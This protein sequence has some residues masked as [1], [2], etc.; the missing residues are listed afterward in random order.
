M[1]QFAVSA[2]ENPDEAS[3]ICCGVGELD[4]GL[5]LREAGSEQMAKKKSTNR[6]REENRGP[7]PFAGASKSLASLQSKLKKLDRE[8]VKRLHERAKL[9][10]DY[11]STLPDQQR[12]LYDP[13]ADDALWAQLEK[14]SGAL[15]FAALRGIYRELL[16]A[17]RRG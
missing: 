17:A 1:S 12:A 10:T 11:L 2:T 4:S 7:S 9:T 15:P 14:Q 16:S 3:L 8:L 6:S 13:V 5:R